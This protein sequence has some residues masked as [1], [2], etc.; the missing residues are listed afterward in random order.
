MARIR[1]IMAR[2]LGDKQLQRNDSF[3]HYAAIL[4]ILCAFNFYFIRCRE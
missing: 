3:L 2:I 1:K 4:G